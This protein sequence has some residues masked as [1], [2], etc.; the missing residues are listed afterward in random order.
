VSRDD[1]WLSDAAH[2]ALQQQTQQHLASAQ[3]ASEKAEK[4]HQQ[5]KALKASR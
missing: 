4:A 1:A 2:A 3:Q 5:A